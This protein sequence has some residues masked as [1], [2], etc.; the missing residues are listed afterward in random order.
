MEVVEET[1]TADHHADD[2]SDDEDDSDENADIFAPKMKTSG[3]R[4]VLYRLTGTSWFI[5]DIY[6]AFC[7]CSP[8]PLF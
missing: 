6:C 3:N 5:R 2:G 7:S 8:P 1:G 4:S